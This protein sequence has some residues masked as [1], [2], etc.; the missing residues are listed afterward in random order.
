MFWKGLFKNQHFFQI[1]HLAMYRRRRVA[2]PYHT[3]GESSPLFCI[4]ECGISDPRVCML[5]SLLWLLCCC[6]FASRKI[7]WTG[8]KN[9]HTS[10]FILSAQ[11]KCLKKMK[12]NIFTMTGNSSWFSCNRS[13]IINLIG[14][15]GKTH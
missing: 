2:S 7:S 15:T 5:I 11:K 8:K 9:Y 3:K 13:L 14:F 12:K 6:C 4:F 10:F 1:I